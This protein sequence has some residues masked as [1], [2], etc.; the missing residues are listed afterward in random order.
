VPD[1]TRSA[2]SIFAFI[3]I[4]IKLG[5]I[6]ATMAFLYQNVRVMWKPAREA[7]IWI[8]RGTSSLSRSRDVMRK[9]SQSGQTASQFKRPP[10]RGRGVRYAE[11]TLDTI[12]ERVVREMASKVGQHDDKEENMAVI[13]L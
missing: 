4:I 2:W 3:E 13:A 8:P 6:I 12:I 10:V 11:D 9:T 5:M 7:W 1:P